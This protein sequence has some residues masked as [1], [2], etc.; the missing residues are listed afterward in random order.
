MNV[1]PGSP[2]IVRR[3]KWCLSIAFVVA[4]CALVCLM[5][6]GDAAL[7]DTFGGWTF[8]LVLV[9]GVLGLSAWM[10]PGVPGGPRNG[11]G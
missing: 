3:A 5:A 1:A 11:E 6:S 2:W 7:L 8:G 9:L 4:L 10:P